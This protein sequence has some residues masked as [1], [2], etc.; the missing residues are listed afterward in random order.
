[1]ANSFGAKRFNE[2]WIPDIDSAAWNHAVTMYVGVLTKY[3]PPGSEGNSFNEIL[4]LITEGKCGMWIVQL[5]Q[6][7][8]YLIQNS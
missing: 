1:M 7:H 8:S 6:H 3:S 2:D 4:A 5:S